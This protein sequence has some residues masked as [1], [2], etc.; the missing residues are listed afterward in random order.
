MPRMW[1]AGKH[2]VG[3]A[4]QQRR[5]RGDLIGDRDLRHPHRPAEQ[6]GRPDQIP[7]RRNAGGAQR[8]THDAIAPRTTEAVVDDDAEIDA[9]LL[10]QPPFI[11]AADASGAHGSSNAARA[12]PIPTFD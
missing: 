11:R 5:S 8:N 9:E 1:T 7:E 6:I 12:R 10:V 3:L 4:H 2:L